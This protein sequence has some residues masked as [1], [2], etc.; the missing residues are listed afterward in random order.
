M[1]PLKTK[2]VQERENTLEREY[3][4][5]IDGSEGKERVEGGKFLA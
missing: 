4:G 2:P 1:E 3:T 5:H